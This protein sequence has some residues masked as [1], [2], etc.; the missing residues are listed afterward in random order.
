[1]RSRCCL[2]VRVCVSV[3]PPSLLGNGSV[4]ILLSLQGN[5]PVKIPLS[6]LGNG[7]GKNPFIIA[8]QRLGR[9][10]NAVTNTHETL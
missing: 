4:K 8:R 7:L 5:G 9:N 1:M 3:Y 6:L 10:V 2:S